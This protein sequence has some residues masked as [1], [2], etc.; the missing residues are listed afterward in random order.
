VSSATGQIDVF[1]R[2]TD[3]ALWHDW[4][5]DGS[6][7]AG[8]QWLG[9]KVAAPPIPGTSGSGVIDVSWRT[10]DESLN[11][12]RFIP[13]SGWVVGMAPSSTPLTSDPTPVSPGNGQMAVVAE[14]F[15]GD[16]WFQTSSA[17]TPANAALTGP[18][19]GTS[20]RSADL[21]RL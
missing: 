12:A 17:T 13:G 16:M 2:G 1:W 7:W 10:T 3:S 5:A 14:A 6:G 15:D 18:T 20:P 4:Y 19:G 21:R 11:E 9:G 8:P